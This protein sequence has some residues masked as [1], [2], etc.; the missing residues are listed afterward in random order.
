MPAEWSPELTLNNDLLDQQHVELFRLLEE[1]AVAL[2]ASAP[3]AVRSAVAAFSESFLE[4][5]A[6]EEALMEDSLYP[7][8]ARHQ[9][10]HELF[11]ADVAQALRDLEANGPTPGVAAWL[12]TRAPEW[13]RFHI[14]TNDLPLGV[15][16]VRSA[17]RSAAGAAQG[18]RAEPR[19][20]LS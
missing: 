14:R 5:V 1:A 20:R 12:R 18:R 19:K 11:A 7:E 9:A 16:L 8:R 2:E 4:H 3:A 15:H 13:L 10:A 17:V 6:A